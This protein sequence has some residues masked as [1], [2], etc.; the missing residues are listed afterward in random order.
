M[1]CFWVYVR[2]VN[3]FCFVNY[4]KP[5]RRINDEEEMRKEEM[6]DVMSVRR[7][8]RRLFFASSKSFAVASSQVFGSFLDSL[9][10]FTWVSWSAYL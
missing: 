1:R 6:V 7:S 5:R 2:V 3:V 10:F 4:E 8:V 9:A